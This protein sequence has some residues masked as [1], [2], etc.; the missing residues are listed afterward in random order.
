MVKSL[1]NNFIA[2]CICALLVFISFLIYFSVYNSNNGGYDKFSFEDKDISSLENELYFLENFRGFYNN[3]DLVDNQVL[4]QYS[5]DSLEEGDYTLQNIE[6]KKNNCKVVDKIAFSSA[7]D[8]DVIAI[9]NEKIKNI[10]SNKLLIDQEIT[11]GDIQH[12]NMDCKN[13]GENYY[14]LLKPFKSNINDYSLVKDIYEKNDKLIIRDYYLRID[15]SNKEVCSNYYDDA[16]CSN[17]IDALQPDLDD[18]VIKKDGLLY[19]ITFGKND[20]GYY[21]ESI[22]II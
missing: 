7:E 21:L 6:S 18:K 11:F 8:C 22:R 20:N 14:C 4:L 10:I 12:K 17:Y 13:N 1:R 5:L 16:Y 15:V 2:V 9:S 3:G 19:E